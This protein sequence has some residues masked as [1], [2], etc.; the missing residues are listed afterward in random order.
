MGI[1][2]SAA[3]F[4]DLARGHHDTVQ[5]VPPARERLTHVGVLGGLR[6][7][8]G[9]DELLDLIRSL[10]CHLVERPDRHGGT[11]HALHRLRRV[12]V[13][14]YP[15][16][17]GELITRRDEVVGVEREEL[18]GLGREFH[19]ISL[20]DSMRLALAAMT[21]AKGDVDGNLERHRDVLRA[22]ASDGCAL[23]VFPE[24]SLTGSVDPTRTPDQLTALDAPCVRELVAATRE[25]GVAA[26]FGVAERTDNGP[27]IT[28]VYA[29]DGE[30]GGVQRKRHLGE[31]EDGY[32]P[33]DDDATFTLGPTRFAIAICAEGGVDRP[34][35]SAAAGGASLVL[36]CSAPG[37][38]GRRRDEAG[39]RDGH[40]WWEGCGL[41][42]AQTQATRHGFWVA[43][44]TQAGSTHDE[45]F[46]GLA[47][48]V[49]PRGEVVTRLPDW[50]PGTLVVDARTR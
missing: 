15:E 12:L 1:G 3:L 4:D 34:W 13:A 16:V 45:D 19:T 23:A 17:L 22:A 10:S 28:Q 35:Q 44:A 43:M 42:D 30:L 25:F 40:R 50:R 18:V 47:A 6:S 2:R 31:G 33:A 14:L 46:P 36:F 21:C 38:H 41:A 11:A 20:A 39:W 9:G 7:R 27:R 5:C 29:H 24:F 49:D 26:V 32:G 37:L 48:L 8:A